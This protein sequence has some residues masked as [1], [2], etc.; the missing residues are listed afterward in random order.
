[1]RSSRSEPTATEVDG[2][3]PT[4]TVAGVAVAILTPSGEIRWCNP[5]FA[6]LAERA[7]SEIDGRPIADALGIERADRVR[8]AITAALRDRT[9]VQRLEADTVDWAG[10]RRRLAL[11]ASP[12]A[13]WHE[14]DH[15]VVV[16]EDL[17]N[18]RRGRGA[19]LDA[20]RRASE[21]A[22]TGLPNRITFDA[23]FES[24]LRRA[25]RNGLPV[26]VLCCD[27]D[28][29]RIIN[30]RLGDAA[31]DQLLQLVGSRLSHTLRHN[32]LLA[33]FTGDEF[34]VVAEEVRDDDLAHLVARRLAAAVSEPFVIS[35]VDV[36]I[37]M[38][39]GFTLSLGH[40][41]PS[42]LLARA[43]LAMHAAKQAGR[44]RSMSYDEA[45]AGVSHGPTTI[46]W[47]ELAQVDPEPAWAATAAPPASQPP[48][49]IQWFSDVD[50]PQP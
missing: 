29:F 16:A 9:M 12:T 4:L 46:D 1:M 5:A 19:T 27:L 10:T 7:P 49:D 11:S 40:D 50:D 39:I 8:A 34:I 3:W 6:D 26:A 45:I 42:D 14:A 18:E 48:P 31:G 30:E 44:G 23:Q 36:R 13:A 32:D 20:A 35:G 47:N 37:G 41:A 2:L 17:T 24:S 22:L 28:G 43:D 15:V 33:R 21:D 38:S 25:Q